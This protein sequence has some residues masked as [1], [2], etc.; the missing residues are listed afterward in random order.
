MPQGEGPRVCR[1]LNASRSPWSGCCWCPRSSAG[2]ITT[3]SALLHRSRQLVPRQRTDPRRAK[4]T[5]S[6]CATAV[7]PS[8]A[9][10]NLLGGVARFQ[11]VKRVAD[12]G[13]ADRDALVL[14]C[15]ADLRRARC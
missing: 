7:T 13:E 15:L 12:R 10:A 11:L 2:S 6:G 4:L 9:V 14:Q 5:V 3:C 8:P 1:C